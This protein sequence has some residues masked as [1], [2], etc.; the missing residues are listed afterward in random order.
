MSEKYDLGNF[1]KI[2]IGIRP[3]VYW[4]STKKGLF[5]AILAVLRDFIAN[6][7]AGRRGGGKYSLTPPPVDFFQILKSQERSVKI[8]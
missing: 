8:R 5:Y 2:P 7:A 4:I 6:L 3:R 1:E